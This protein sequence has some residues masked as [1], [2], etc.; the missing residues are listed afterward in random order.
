[1]QEKHQQEKEQL[2][3]L[4]FEQMWEYCTYLLALNTTNGV[5]NCF[6]CNCLLHCYIATFT[7]LHIVSHSCSSYLTALCT[8]C[9]WTALNALGYLGSDGHAQWCGM[10]IA[11]MCW[12][13][14]QVLMVRSTLSG[15]TCNC[16]HTR[17]IIE[18]EECT[19]NFTLFHHI[20]LVSH[21]RA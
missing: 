2:A 15:Q 19:S 5:S 10:R 9:N 13:P 7:L 21:V 4:R 14:Q 20:L 8:S 6:H 11:R 18:V 17:V 12:S 3:D 1:M 16:D